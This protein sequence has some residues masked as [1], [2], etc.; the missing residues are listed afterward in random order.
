VNEVL[1]EPTVESFA[2]PDEQ[3][4]DDHT[5]DREQRCAR[6]RRGV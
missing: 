3:P 6:M 2:P 5:D 1:S 4:G